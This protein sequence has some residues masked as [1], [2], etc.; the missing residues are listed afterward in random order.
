MMDRNLHVYAANANAG[1]QKKE[2]QFGHGTHCLP[3]SQHLT[4]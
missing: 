3:F 2:E 1:A 4:H